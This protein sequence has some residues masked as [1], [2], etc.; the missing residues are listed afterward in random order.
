MDWSKAKTY[1][2]IAFAITNLLLLWSI[3]EDR[4]AGGNGDFFSKEARQNLHALLQKKQIRLACDLPKKRKKMGLLRVAYAEVDQE[5]YPAFFLD[6][7][8]EVEIIAGR[9]IL[10]TTTEP[11]KEFNLEEGKEQATTFLELYGL[12]KDFA[13]RNGLVMD[14]ELHLFYDGIVDDTYL[15]GSRME[16]IFRSSGVFQLR[17][18]K[19]DVLEKISKRK[20]TKNSVEAVMQVA[21]K[22]DP[23]ETI[24][25]I[26]L[27]YYYEEFTNDPLMKTK[28]ATAFPSWRI[29]TKSGKYYFVQAIDG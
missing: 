20:L 5:Q 24:Q 23:G 19:L 25:E 6:H 12:G 22:M 27:G 7:A 8:D 13:F 3:I 29:G 18:T 11:L 16:I 26:K 28:I 4:S 9:Q 17:R 21:D 14:G 10:L 1:L 2:I 15:E